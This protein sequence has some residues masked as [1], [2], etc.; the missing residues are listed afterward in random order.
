MH[1]NL[2]LWV[3]AGKGFKYCGLF[4]F[5][6]KGKGRL[7]TTTQVSLESGLPDILNDAVVMVVCAAD[8]EVSLRNDHIVGVFTRYQVKVLKHGTDATRSILVLDL[9][10]RKDG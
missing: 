7:N 9:K 2:D 4:P 3:S 5:E 10:E 1:Y 6:D 8:R